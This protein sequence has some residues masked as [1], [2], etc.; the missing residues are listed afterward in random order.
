MTAQEGVTVYPLTGSSVIVTS[1]ELKLALS[2][3]C[4]VEYISGFI[5]PFKK[6]NVNKKTGHV[7]YALNPYQLVLKDFITE[8]NKYPKMHPFNLLYKLYCVGTYGL[9]TPSPPLWGG[10]GGISPKKTFSSRCGTTIEIS[11][12]ELSNPIMAQANYGFCAGSSIRRN[13]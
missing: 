7:S 1:Y 6:E 9:V 3:G 10:R 5:I 8:R 11:H 13:T 2:I 12:G 4:Y